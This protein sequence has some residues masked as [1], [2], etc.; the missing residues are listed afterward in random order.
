MPDPLPPPRQAGPRARGPENSPQPVRRPR[1]PP[2]AWRRNWVFSSSQFVLCEELGL[3]WVQQG[4]PSLP[5]EGLGWLGTMEVAV[6]AQ[7]LTE[8]FLHFMAPLLSS[9]GPVAGGMAVLFQSW[10]SGGAVSRLP[11][12]GRRPPCLGSSEPAKE[13]C[14]A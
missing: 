8:G 9:S 4:S 13:S 1:L 5:P 7:P 2:G 6:Q 11:V 12:D 14:G 3:L 10:G